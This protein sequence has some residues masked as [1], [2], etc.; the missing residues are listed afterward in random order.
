MGARKTPGRGPKAGGGVLSVG[1]GPGA[2]RW[3]RVW[4]WKDPPGFEG[5]LYWSG[6]VV[7]WSFCCQSPSRRG[8]GS[9][10]N[11]GATGS[12]RDAGGRGAWDPSAGVRVPVAAG[13]WAG[14]LLLR[15][16]GRRER[17]RVGGGVGA[18]LGSALQGLPP[19]LPQG[20][21]SWPEARGNKTAQAVCARVL[22]AAREGTV[23]QGAP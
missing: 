7:V 21:A 19:A 6:C 13:P 9:L 2:T 22:R 15:S 20:G 18:L 23:G 11:E 5:P 1:D 16:A 8:S 14:R 12:C 17:P 3:A 10:E 4:L